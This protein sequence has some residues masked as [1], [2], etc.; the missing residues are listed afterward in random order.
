VVRRERRER[1]VLRVT[2]PL[3]SPARTRLAVLG[4]P[5]SHSRSPAIHR[6]AYGVLGLDWSYESADVTGN[7]LA[8]Y[9]GSRDASW[10]GL[11]LT[12]P[13]KRDILPLLDFRDP[14]VERVRGANTVLF[15]DDGLRGFNT[16]V[17]GV[18]AALGEHGITSVE[19]VHVLGGGATAASVIVALQQLGL[20]HALVSVRSPE[21]S[22]DLRHLGETVGVTVDVGGFATASHGADLLVNTIPGRAEVD[23]DDAPLLAS[24]TPFF[25]VAYD[26]WPSPRAA[27]WDAAG[28]ALISGLDLLIHQAIGQVRIF[29]TGDQREPLPSEPAVVAAMRAA[30]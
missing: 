14:L 4:S 24:R 9:I 29:L 25:E 8:D 20:Q 12:M 26:P 3:S 15:G 10:R 2:A 1:L 13:L 11:S 16:D 5:I 17:Q 6:A 21:R 22:A 27:K 23:F 18:I 30:A 28:L 7:S 19:R